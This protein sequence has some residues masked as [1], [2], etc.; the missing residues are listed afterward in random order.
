M[1]LRLLRLLFSPSSSVTI[2]N[3][4]F[5]Q[6]FWPDGCAGDLLLFVLLFEGLLF[7]LERCPHIRLLGEFT[8]RKTADKQD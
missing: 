7:Q 1:S 6:A 3:R 2:K 8:S 5:N 4:G